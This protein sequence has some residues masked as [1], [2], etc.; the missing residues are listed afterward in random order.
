MK[1]DVIYERGVLKI[2]S[3]AEIDTDEIT[4][5]IIS[6][7]EVLTETDMRDILDA[8]SAKEKGDYYKYEGVFE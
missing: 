8:I 3:P 1:V 7:D 6:R 4:V 2:L 5:H